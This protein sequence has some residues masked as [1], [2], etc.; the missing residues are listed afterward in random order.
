MEAR[1]TRDLARRQSVFCRSTL[2]QDIANEDLEVAAM[3]D[4]RQ[5]ATFYY[6]ELSRDKANEWRDISEKQRGLSEWRWKLQQGLMEIS[7]KAPGDD[8]DRHHA[9]PSDLGD[10]E[11]PLAPRS[12]PCESPKLKGRPTMRGK[13]KSQGELCSQRNPW[14]SC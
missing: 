11:M 1:Y 13:K 9:P 5:A 6:Q 3:A 7:K 4:Y 12:S 14:W 2:D 8:L 10:I